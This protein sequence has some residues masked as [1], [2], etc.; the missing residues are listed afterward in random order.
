M[1]FESKSQQR[2]MYANKPEM[3]KKWSDHTP[4]HKSLPE[5]S[6]KKKKRKEKQAAFVALQKM[7]AAPPAGAPGLGNRPKRTGGAPPSGLGI[8]TPG[9]M[10]PQQP[11]VDPPQPIAPPILD[12][13]IQLSPLPRPEKL[14]PLP[15]NA[16]EG[17]GRRRPRPPAAQNPVAQNPAAQPQQPNNNLLG[18]VFPRTYSRRDLPAAPLGHRTARARAA[19][20]RNAALTHAYKRM[21]AL[22]LDERGVV[23]EPYN[24]N[25]EQMRNAAHYMY[26]RMGEQ[27]RLNQLYEQG[28]PSPYANKFEYDQAM[29]K[30]F[31]QQPTNR[32]KLVD[33]AKKI[34]PDMTGFGNVPKNTLQDL[35][36]LGLKSLEHH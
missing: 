18:G 24:L 30:M 19:W 36:R 34:Y 9:D 28:Q 20:E 7:S 12:P 29:K 26:P 15:P 10:L 6:K 22:N 4:D 31:S 16:F 17:L 21:N 14:P 3:A 1:P 35:K 13:N 32:S 27:Y 23:Q 33:L 8:G 2:W 11:V 25:P 5:K